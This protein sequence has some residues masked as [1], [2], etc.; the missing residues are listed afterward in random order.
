MTL[1]KPNEVYYEIYRAAREK[2]KHMRKVAL[3]AYL[4]AQQIKTKYMLEDLD[5]SDE[6]FDF[7][8]KE[9][10]GLTSV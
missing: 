2:A 5:E 4:E 1:K 6:E 7:T 3:E 9:V 8:E 10:S